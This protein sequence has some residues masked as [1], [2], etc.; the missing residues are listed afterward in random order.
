[1]EEVFLNFVRLRTDQGRAEQ[2]AG[3]THNQRQE[4]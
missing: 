4:K 3:V 2:H 1:V